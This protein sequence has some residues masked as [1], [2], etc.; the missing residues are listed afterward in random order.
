LKNSNNGVDFLEN[1]NQKEKEF[2]PFGY[3]SVPPEGSAKQVK[4]S[5]RMPA[6]FDFSFAF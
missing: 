1:N 5:R 2:F 6:L 4:K 3:Y